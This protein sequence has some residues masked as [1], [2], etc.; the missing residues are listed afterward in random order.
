MTPTPLGALAVLAIGTA[1]AAVTDAVPNLPDLTG[2]E[3]QVAAVIRR[4][5]DDLRREPGS[6]PRW[7]HYASILD[8][9]MLPD[10]A[11]MA[12]ETAARLD[13]TDF[14]WPYLLGLL[15]ASDDPAWSLSLL[16][17]AMQLN[18]EY[19][20]LHLRYAGAMEFT[21]NIEAA[22]SSYQR[23]VE[24]DPDSAYAHAGLGR[25]LLDA[26]KPQQA[27][28]HLD[29]AVELDGGCR[30]ALSALATYCRHSGDMAGA[31]RWAGRASDAPVGYPRDEVR[32]A[33]DRLGMSTTAALLQASALQTAGHPDMAIRRL[34]LLTRQNPD[35]G[36]G[37][38]KLGELYLAAGNID[39]AL[40]HLRIAVA[41]EP[42]F[43]PARLTL[44]HA[45][46]R[47]GRLDEADQQYRTVLEGHPTSVAAH[48]GL[49]ICLADMG[50]LDA[51]AEQFARVLKLSPDDR[52]ARAAWGSALYGSGQYQRAIDVLATMV[53]GSGPPADD[54]ALNAI[55]GT[56]LSMAMLRRYEEAL[57]LLRRAVAAAPRRA[58][59]HRSLSIALYGLGQSD[60]AIEQLQEAVRLVPGNPALRGELAE[61]H[62]ASGDV[63]EAAAALASG[64]KL[65]A[66]APNARQ[67]LAIRYVRVADLLARRGDWTAA[68]SVLYEG[69]ALLP[70]SVEILNDLAWRLATAPDVAMRDGAKAV[71]LAEHANALAGGESCNELD[72][73][74]ASYARA[75]RFDDA[76]VAAEYALAIATRAEQ[77]QLASQIAA[78]LDLFKRGNPYP[79]P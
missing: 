69:L 16:E 17:R 12:Y 73:L 11:T 13:P 62:A 46:T 74:A 70:D 47:A 77:H 19:V 76:I 29:R 79:S 21:G 52:K 28:R 25:C 31:E 1:A 10:E 58:D 27:K 15:V 55:A 7:A 50:R 48:R 78:R 20:P 60:G 5:H 59:L 36:R 38:K 42:A 8:V 43:I 35:S 65:V 45:L 39:T 63:T 14:R 71:E 18:D 33:V 3:P 57:A 24:L 37:R 51:A 61:L 40:E 9:H 75:G 22:L 56:G 6:A 53:T 2:A 34:E 30:P 44:A 68:I 41:V 72:T 54:L 49:A 32:A 23:A 67:G 66:D 26:D 4:A 64:A